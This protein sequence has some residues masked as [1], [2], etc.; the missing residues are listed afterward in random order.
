V[1]DYIKF[2]IELSF[3]LSFVPISDP[4][5]IQLEWIFISFC[6][7]LMLFGWKYTF[8]ADELGHLFMLLLVLRYTFDSSNSIVI[9]N[10]EEKNIIN[11][12]D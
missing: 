4:K 7:V 2:L 12:N 8:I 6:S 3:T 1:F 10:D 11:K 5:A 9:E